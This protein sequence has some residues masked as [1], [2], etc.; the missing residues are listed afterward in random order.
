[1]TLQ[2]ILCNCHLLNV[3]RHAIFEKYHTKKGTEGLKFNPSVPFFE[4]HNYGVRSLIFNLNFKI[5]DLTPKMRGQ[6]SPTARNVVSRGC[7]TNGIIVRV[8]RFLPSLI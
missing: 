5:K 2:F 1:M 3:I 6:G 7:D 8:M 4:L